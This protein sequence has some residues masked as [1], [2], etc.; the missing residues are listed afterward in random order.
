MRGKFK[1]LASLTRREETYF[2]GDQNVNARII[3]SPLDYIL[4]IVTKVVLS[5]CRW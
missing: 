2:I 1:V 5:I 3:F 4:G